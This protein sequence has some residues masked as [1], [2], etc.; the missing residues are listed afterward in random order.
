MERNPNFNFVNY[1]ENLEYNSGKKNVRNGMLQLD[2]IAKEIDLHNSIVYLS[3]PF[4]MVEAFRQFLE[5][6]GI[7]KE[8]LKI[9]NWE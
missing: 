7:E 8:N 5:Q 2:T 3:G 9:D 1:N 4:A 6:A